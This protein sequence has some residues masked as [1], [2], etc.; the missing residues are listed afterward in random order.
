MAKGSPEEL[1]VEG[2]RLTGPDKV[3]YP[4]Q[5]VVNGAAATL[6]PRVS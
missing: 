1:V 3:L 4:E 6:S 2:V 5:G